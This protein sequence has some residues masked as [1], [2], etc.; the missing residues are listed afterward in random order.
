[1]NHKQLTTQVKIISISYS[2]IRLK[3]LPDFSIRV[4]YLLEVVGYDDRVHAAGA[5][6]RSEQAHQDCHPGKETQTLWQIRK[7][8]QNS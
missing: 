3:Y 4:M 1:M 6:V 2:K 7:G 5:E 8:N